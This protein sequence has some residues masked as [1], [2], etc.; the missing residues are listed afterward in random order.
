MMRESLTPASFGI[1]SPW[2][3]STWLPS[4]TG[5]LLALPWRHSS[6]TGQALKQASLTRWR[7][8]WIEGRGH[9]FIVSPSFN[10]SP[11]TWVPEYAPFD[12]L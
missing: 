8:D 1:A 3:A 5:R 9:R 4:L 2:P 12:A 10:L 7:T 11:A 6:R